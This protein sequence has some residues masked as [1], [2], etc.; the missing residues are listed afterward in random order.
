MLFRW[1]VTLKQQEQ[2]SPSSEG[3]RLALH[4]IFHNW[5]CTAPGARIERAII[6][7]HFDRSGATALT[8]APGLNGYSPCSDNAT[9]VVCS[10]RYR[11]T[12]LGA[13]RNSTGLR[14]ITSCLFPCRRKL[15][16]VTASGELWR[17]IWRF[18]CLLCVVAGAELR[19]VYRL[20]GLVADGDWIPSRQSALAFTTNS[21]S[22]TTTLNASSICHKQWCHHPPNRL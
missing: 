22:L 15:V 21:F 2:K 17:R 7:A 16:P 18:Q 11:S 1:I 10:S 9:S 20:R 4:R 5:G 8:E 14:R 12:W 6:S 3:R 13:Y 19:L